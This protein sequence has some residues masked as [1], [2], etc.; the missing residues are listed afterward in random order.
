MSIFVVAVHL[1]VAWVRSNKG[2]LRF[3]CHPALNNFKQDSETDIV[4][5]VGHTRGPLC[6]FPRADSEAA[7]LIFTRGVYFK[8]QRNIILYGCIPL[9]FIGQRVF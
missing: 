5:V 4:R 6:V 7:S 8:I 3:H 9:C 2:A 1:S